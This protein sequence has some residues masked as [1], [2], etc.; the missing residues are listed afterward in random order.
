MKVQR[1]IQK[2]AD[3]ANIS[4]TSLAVMSTLLN[5]IALGSK[6]GTQSYGGDRNIYAALGYPES[7]TFDN[8]L[9][10]YFRQDMA[11]AIIDRPVKA[12]WKGDIT[13]LENTKTKKTKFEKQWNELYTK[14][15]LKS[16][17]VRADKL[18]GLG[19]YSVLL[20][21][22]N[23]VT[24]NVGFRNKVRKGSKLVYVKPFSEESATIEELENDQ[25]NKRY[26]LPKYYKIR[27]KNEK[28]SSSSTRGKTKMA[29]TFDDS[30]IVHYSR[31]IHIT[32]DIL[33]DEIYGL[34]SLEVVFNRLLD[35]EKL[36]GGD[37]EMFWRGARPGYTGSVK[38][39]YEMTPEMLADL[40]DQIKE[41]EHN[42][43]RVLVNEGID[44][45]SLEQQIADPSAHVDVQVQMISA[46]KGI[47]K[48]ILIGSERGELSSAQDKQ[49]WDS[50]V[51][52][53]RE[54]VNE[55]CILRPFIDHMIEY[56]IIE[57]PKNNDY[58]IIWDKLFSLS[59]KEKVDLGK[60]RAVALKEY[61]TNP[62]AQYMIPYDMFLKFLLGLDDN[63]ISTIVEHRKELIASGEIKELSIEEIAKLGQPARQFERTTS[64]DKRTES[65]E[66]KKTKRGN[67]QKVE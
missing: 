6:V 10:R 50:Y 46:V 43:K 1:T 47:P 61:S 33:E 13:V 16:I 9:G 23:D 67:I 66:N 49:E 2:K 4:P 30:I 27:L 21:G 62:A 56:K 60:N 65:G 51:A 36:V 5:R 52:S 34:P 45:K 64:K 42:L 20:L 25:R 15:K 12:S 63:Q 18:T 55:P 11:K 39:D 59:D 48:R 40:Q 14:L 41:F 57:A 37:A 19:R 7:L 3:T 28:L 32:E 58:I 29:A 38:P 24:S 35:L 17:F 26:G 22:L 53:R 31:V 54:E 8:F 44:Y